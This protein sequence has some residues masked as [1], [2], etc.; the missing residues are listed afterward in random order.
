MADE[1]HR[2]VRFDTHHPQEDR[3]DP[4]VPRT[5]A[6]AERRTREFEALLKKYHGDFQKATDAQL[7]GEKADLRNV[8]GSANTM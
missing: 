1:R 2:H 5:W 8:R 3:T 4:V 7:R 6:D